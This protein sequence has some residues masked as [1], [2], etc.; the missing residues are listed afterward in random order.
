VASSDKYFAEEESDTLSSDLRERM[1]AW[2]TTLNRTGLR[3]RWVKSY[4]YY[5]G[6][7]FSGMSNTFNSGSVGTAGEHGELKL[8]TLNHYRNLLKHIHILTTNQKPAFDVRAIN[9]DYDSLNQAKLGNAILDA[10]LNE[11]RLYRYF[12][13]AAEHALVFGKGFVHLTWEPSLGRQVLPQPYVDDQGQEKLKMIYEGDVDCCNPSPF[14]VLVDQGCDDFSRAEW[15]VI[16]F[17][18]NKYALANRYGAQ[19][20]PEVGLRIRGLETV[21]ENQSIA[22]MNGNGDQTTLVPVYA[23]YHKRSDALTNGRFM[24]FC[25]DDIVLYD[26]PI[27]YERLPLFR[28]VPG[29]IFG[30]T[31]GYTD[32]FDLMGPQEVID[33]LGSAAFSNQSA[34]GVQNVL[35]P[36]NCNLQVTT[37]ADGLRGLSYNPSAGK[38]EALQLTATPKELFDMI[39]LMQNNMELFSASIPSREETPKL[40]W[41]RTHQR[42]YG[43]DSVDGCAVC[44]GLPAIV[45]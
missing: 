20:G 24:L 5:F 27:Q 29:E 37:L 6:R 17:F 13:T 43:S 21:N 26:G 18:R 34:F 19:L 11:K 33:T 32:G 30:T 8:L 10:Y 28:I 36:E 45:G 23:F 25:D 4:R 15:C 40:R 42:R 12:K 2:G 7:H 22:N 3:D 9:N 14:D 1:V 35:I 41:A 44:V 39:E 38:P 31:E 16:R